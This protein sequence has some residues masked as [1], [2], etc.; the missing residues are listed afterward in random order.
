MNHLAVLS[1]AQPAYAPAGAALVSATAIGLPTMDDSAL[2]LAAKD[3]LRGWFGDEVRRWRL[4]RVDRIRR[5]L[6]VVFGKGGGKR[7]GMRGVYVCGDWTRD[8]SINGAMESG[9]LAAGE[10]LR[11]L[12]VTA[13]V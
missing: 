8:P 2:D 12:G 7:A 11:D 6:P 10:V 9:G 4:L 1:D 3:Q 5:A 13:A